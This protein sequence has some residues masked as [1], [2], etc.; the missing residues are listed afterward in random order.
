MN[1]F[2]R[3]AKLHLDK[4]KFCCIYLISGLDSGQD[5][6]FESEFSSKYL[7]LPI[8]LSLSD[9]CK[10]HSAL[11]SAWKSRSDMLFSDSF[12]VLP[13]NSYQQK[14]YFFLASQQILQKKIEFCPDFLRNSLEAHFTLKPQRCLVLKAS[15]ALLFLEFICK[16]KQE[17]GPSA[18]TICLRLTLWIAHCTWSMTY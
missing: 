1:Q 18:M 2:L 12:M 4:T 6:S 14:S 10:W 13:Q 5:V 3:N 17:N 16:D 8:Q 7:L 11:C 15:K 9:H